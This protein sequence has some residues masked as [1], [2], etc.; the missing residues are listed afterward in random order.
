MTAPM[1]RAFLRRM[2]FARLRPAGPRAGNMKRWIGG[3]RFGDGAVR[4]RRRRP[5]L[6]V[7]PVVQ[8]VGCRLHRHGRGAG[9]CARPRASCA[10]AMRSRTPSPP[11]HA[12]T[13]RLRLAT[14]TRRTG[15]GRW[16]CRAA[17]LPGGCRN[18]SAHR[19]SDRHHDAQRSGCIA[20][21]RPPC[22]ISRPRR[23]RR[24]QA[25]ADGVNA[26]IAQHQEALAHR[27]RARRR[28]AARALARRRTASRC[29]RAW[30][31]SFPKTCSASWRG[32]SLMPRLGRE[33]VQEFFAPFDAA[34]LPDW[35]ETLFNPTQVGGV[36]I[37]DHDGIGQL[38]GRRPPQRHRQA[39]AGQR[40]AP[41]ICHP[42]G[43]VPRAPFVRRRRSRGRHAARHTRHH[44]RA[45]RAISPGAS[46]MSGPTRRI[47]IWSGST[48]R[49]RHEYQTPDGW[50]RVRRR[51]SRPS[52]CASAT[53][54][55]S[56]VRAT[57]HG[58]VM[59][60]IG[61]VRRR[62]AQGLRDGAAVDGADAGRHDHRGDSRAEPCAERATI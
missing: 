9:A 35:Y 52:R 28:Y 17:P 46:P 43:L 50:A 16:R 10:T 39:V 23:A 24:L 53:T 54:A 8:A 19:R 31:S 61:A 47:C 13:P 30:R 59:P 29:S 42:V 49:I 4:R 58:P 37:P 38:G 1:R 14:R 18:C 44:R 3:H 6:R 51:A 25:Y 60:D 2:L 15:C 41:G 40:S 27:V 57:R 12:R 26:Y 62:G 7:L 55:T 45:H 20:P 34:P 48:R 5:V 56:S 32:R 33:R 22:P 21:P 11:R 36:E